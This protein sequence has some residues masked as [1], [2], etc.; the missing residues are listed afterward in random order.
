MSYFLFNLDTY[1]RVMLILALTLIFIYEIINGFHDTANS[2]VSVI[3]TCAL[4]PHNAVLIS[5]VFNFLGVTLSGL[6]VAYTIVH[7]LPTYFFTNT[8]VNNTLAMIFSILFAAILWNLGTWYLRLPTSSSHTLIGALIGIGFAHAIITNCPITHGLNISKLIKI[9]LSLIISPIIGLILAK[10]IMLILYKYCDYTGYD[11]IHTTPTKKLKTYGKSQPSLWTRTMLIISA[12]G[13]SFS[14]GANDGQKGIGLIMLLLIGIAPASFMLNLNSSNYDIART[15]HAINDFQEYYIKHNNSF[16]NIVPSEI[17]SMPITRAFNQLKILFPSI[18]KSIQTII[19]NDKHA[20][21]YNNNPIQT[22][23][24]IKKIFHD[25]SLNLTM[26]HN[27]SLLLNNLD[28][29]KKL[30]TTQRLQIRQLLIYIVDILDQIID[31][32]ETSHHDKYFLKNLKENLLYTIEYAPTC[33]IFAV[34]LSLSLG[35]IIGWKRVA[36]TIGEKIGTKEMTYAQGL[37]TQLTTAISISTASYVGMP[38]STTHILSSSITGSM[39]TQ[40]WKG[41]QIKTIK[42]I[43]ITWSLT[44]PVSITLSGSFYWSTLKLLH[45]YI[46]I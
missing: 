27:I 30:N 5:G 3:Y 12:A 37:S 1:V 4:R 18:E 32:P 29:Y 31:L 20:A 23:I 17:I 26:M 11:S 43:L 42:N 34:A 28:D 15:N 9:F 46:Q 39:L 44:F 24:Q 35:T 40:N 22:D 33:I 36:I 45:K 10:L 2:V 25:F 14:H 8:S 6:S 21:C 38:V 13:V 19:Y 41:I 7:L 16:R